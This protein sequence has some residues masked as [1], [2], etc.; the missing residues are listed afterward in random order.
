MN[1]AFNCAD[2]V[3]R[4]HIYRKTVKTLNALFC[5]PYSEK[6]EMIS[7]PK[8]CQMGLSS[9]NKLFGAWT[10]GSAGQCTNKDAGFRIGIKGFRRVM[11]QVLHLKH[12]TKYILAR[13]NKTNYFS[14]Q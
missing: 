2:L 13:G 14:S 4:Y 6:Q 1:Y 8:S 3:L 9:C 7:Q 5:L 12:L 11:M 10:V